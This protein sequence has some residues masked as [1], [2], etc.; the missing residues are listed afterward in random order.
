MARRGH[1]RYR[2]FTLLELLGAL[3]VVSILLA[4]AVPR[5]NAALAGLVLDQAAR[6]L[7]AD[8]Q[9][10]RMKAVARNA[11]VRVVVESEPPSYRVEAESESTFAAEGERRALPAGVALDLAASTRASSGRVTVTFQPRGNTADNCTIALRAAAGARRDV[12]VSPIGRV[13]LS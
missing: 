7:A 13:R 3:A 6:R 10:A 5:I 8:L 12:V 11:R 4:T 1:R 9:L 2:G